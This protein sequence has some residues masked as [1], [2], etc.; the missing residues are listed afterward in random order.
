MKD[1]MIIGVLVLLLVVGFIAGFFIC[2]AVRVKP[3]ESVLQE[4]RREKEELETAIDKI[5]EEK[6]EAIRNAIEKMDPD[7]VIDKYLN[8]DM[9]GELTDGADKYTREIVRA[10]FEWIREFVR[11]N[12]TDPVTIRERGG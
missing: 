1:W 3:L 10:V 8:D 7:T 11:E 4:A 9:L 2:N 12:K 6:E 5:Q